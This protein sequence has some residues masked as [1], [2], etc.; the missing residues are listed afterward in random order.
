MQIFVHLR[1]FGAQASRNPGTCPQDTDGIRPIIVCQSTHF[2]FG[3][4]IVQQHFGITED[5]NRI[6]IERTTVVVRIVQAIL[7]RL[8]ACVRITIEVGSR[9]DTVAR[10][11]RRADGLRQTLVAVLAFVVKLDLLMVRL[12]RERRTVCHQE[13]IDERTN[14]TE[15]RAIRTRSPPP[16]GF[17]QDA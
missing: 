11:T 14:H 9:R 3:L 2:R 15:T 1:R 16:V 13:K 7:D 6:R 8:V 10:I 5:W 4:G 12:I 17:A